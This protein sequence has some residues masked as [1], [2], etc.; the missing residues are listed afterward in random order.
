M[1]S[2]PKPAEP[3]TSEVASLLRVGSPAPGTVSWAAV[4]AGKGGRGCF[5]SR[6]ASG[7]TR[8]AA[9]VAEPAV[10]YV[11]RARGTGTTHPQESAAGGAPA[12]TERG[13]R[14]PSCPSGVGEAPRGSFEI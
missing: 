10:K 6:R 13:G 14:K 7:S 3:R 1:T 12:G 4:V 8:E 2:P 9:P 5:C 11:R